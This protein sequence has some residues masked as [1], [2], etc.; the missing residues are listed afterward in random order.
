VR[1]LKSPE[2][3]ETIAAVELSPDARY[4]AV[5]GAQ[6]TSVR[7]FETSSGRPVGPALMHKNTV[8]CAAFSPDGRMLLTG[9]SDNMARVWAVPGGDLLTP[10][11]DL[12]RPVYSVGFPHLGRSLVTQDGDLVRLWALPEEGVPIVRAPLDGNRSFVALSPDGTLA[13][14]TGMTFATPA[15]H[16]TRAYRVTTGQPAGPILRP[17]GQVV[18]AAFSPD[19]KSVATLAARVGSSP[20][21]QEVVAWDWASGRHRWRAALPFHPRSLGYRGDGRRLAVLCGDGQLLFF[22]TADGREVVRWES[23]QPENLA[24]AHWINNGKVAFSPDDRSVLTWGLTEDV[25]VWDPDTGLLRYPPLRHRDKCHDVQFSPDGR[26]MALASYDG[27]VRVRDVETGAVLVELPAHP[28]IAYSAR[29]SPDGRMLVTACRDH[30]VRVW[31]WRAGLLVCPP[32]E[33]V[34]EVMNAAFTPDGRR[35]ISA[36]D[37]ETARVW[38][39]K[40]GKPL[41]PPLAMMG[42]PM[43]VAVTPDGKHAVVGGFQS[44]MAVLDL[45][46]LIPDDKHF[47]G[48]VL[49]LRAELLAGQR[50]HEGGGTV[51][52]AAHEWFDR[53]RAFRR[54]SPAA[55]LAN[56]M[57]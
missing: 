25:R 57:R 16:S 56:P 3:P 12:H 5:F 45:G 48:D 6:A 27:S 49:C 33:H 36:S 39:L 26:S 24:A 19:G 23:H 13:I 35:V 4:L 15:L 40:T 30:M 38:D 43:S 44:T 52:L 32:F 9:S 29:F 53:W 2:V 47:E 37:D 41:T 11:L 18:D 21:G 10:P 50:L 17:G 51:N 28:D 8:Y 20:E 22:D 42:N 14:P 55:G 34:K 46:D 54:Q 31:D 7:L 1:S